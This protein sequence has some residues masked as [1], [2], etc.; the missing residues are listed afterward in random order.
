[1]KTA[2]QVVGAAL[3]RTGKKNPMKNN[4]FGKRVGDIKL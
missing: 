1:M 2:K 4:Y 3:T